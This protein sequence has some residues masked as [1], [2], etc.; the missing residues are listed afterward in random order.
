MY[1]P[2]VDIYSNT[3]KILVREIVAY[4]KSLTRVI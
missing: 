2:F 1:K 3:G 4:K